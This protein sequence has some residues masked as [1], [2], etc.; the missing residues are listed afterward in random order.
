[1][2]NVNM[3]LNTKYQPEYVYSGVVTAVFDISASLSV[4]GGDVMLIGRIP[5]GAIPLDAV[6]YPDP[7]TTGNG[8]FVAKFGTS[9]SQELFFISATYS[10]GAGLIRCSR[11]LG[12][13]MQISLSDDAAVRY[14]NITMVTTAGMSLGHIGELAV[15]YR[16][17]GQSKAP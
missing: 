8:T 2:A 12:S 17:P 5:H 9:Q 11:R 16:M 14:D 13:A 7:S 15:T 1:M 10:G 4:S 3:G 6:F